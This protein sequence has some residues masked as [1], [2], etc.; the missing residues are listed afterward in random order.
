MTQFHSS[1]YDG[2][3]H[4]KM[5]ESLAFINLKGHIHLQTKRRI[6]NYPLFCT[7]A[8]ALYPDVKMTNRNTKTRL[9][10]STARIWRFGCLF[11]TPER[12]E[13]TICTN[14]PSTN[15]PGFEGLTGEEK[16]KIRITSFGYT[17][18]LALST[19]TLAF[20]YEDFNLKFEMSFSRRDGF[21]YRHVLFEGE[22]VEEE[23]ASF[24][25]AIDYCKSHDSH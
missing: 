22:T 12:K 3:P 17:D 2:Q 25:E 15:I 10:P 23:F 7:K 14:T 21:C 5:K 24:R 6:F 20:T 19:V 13:W 16:L 8:Q 4:R 18:H 1:G 9:F 11:L